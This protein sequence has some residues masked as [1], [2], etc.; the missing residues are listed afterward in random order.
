MGFQLSKND[1][2]KLE[3]VHPDLVRVVER[4]AEISET[5]FTILEGLRSIERQKQLLAK[6]ASKTMRS[7][8]IR[9]A[10]GFGHAVDIAPLKGTKPSWDWK[11]YHPLAK[12]IKKAAED[13]GVKIEWGGDWKSFPDGPHWQLPWKEYPG[14]TV[15]AASL[16][17]LSSSRTIQGSVTASAG[18]A[19]FIGQALYDVQ[20]HLEEAQEKFSAG[21]Y[22]SIAIGVLVLAGAFYAIYA[23]WDDAGRPLPWKKEQDFEQIPEPKDD[24]TRMNPEGE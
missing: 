7:R 21:D 23:R 11:D 10:N 2:T 5:K 19:Y 1:R 8:H 6:G 14:K 12:T 18:G 13:V 24:F 17:D 15:A 3:G 16:S 9:A 4:A 22:L 20:G